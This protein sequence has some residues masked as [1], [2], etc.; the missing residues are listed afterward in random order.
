MNT[1]RIENLERDIQIKKLPLGK[2]SELIQSI[3]KELPELWKK[4]D[5]MDTDD[6]GAMFEALPEIISGALPQ[7]S[8]I[9]SIATYIRTDDRKLVKQLDEEDFQDAVGLDE[10]VDIAF[11]AWESNNLKK[12]VDKAKKFS[13]KAKKMAQ[14]LQSNPKP[15]DQK[16]TG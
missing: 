11:A 5:G 15:S 8:K 2:Y 6:E 4:F 3:D 7:F 10:A 9:L 13:P 12:L 1:I 14:G 16:S